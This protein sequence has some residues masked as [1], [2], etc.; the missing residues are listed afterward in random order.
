MMRECACG[1][2]QTL[3]IAPVPFGGVSLTLGEGV[4]RVRDEDVPSLIADLL[5]ASRRVDS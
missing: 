1:C 5:T 4:L 3:S 2:G